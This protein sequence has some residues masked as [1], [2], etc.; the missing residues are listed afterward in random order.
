L[1][2]TRRFLCLSASGASLGLVFKAFLFI[3]SLLAFRKD[4]ILTAVFAL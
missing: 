3:E 2:E 4:K 1:L